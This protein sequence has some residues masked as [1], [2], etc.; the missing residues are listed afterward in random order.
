MSAVAVAAHPGWRSA[1]PQSW[2]D[3]SRRAPAL[4]TT[5]SAYLDALSGRLEGSLSLSE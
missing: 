5:V 4:M 2:V 3:I 1:D